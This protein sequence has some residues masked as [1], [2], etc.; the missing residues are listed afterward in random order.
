MFDL[1]FICFLIYS[2]KQP[3]GQISLFPSHWWPDWGPELQNNIANKWQSWHTNPCNFGANVGKHIP[4]ASS[5]LAWK[6]KESPISF[7]F[8]HT[9]SFLSFPLF[10]P[11]SPS[12]PPLLSFLLCSNLYP[13]LWQF[14]LQGS[15]PDFETLC[16][17]WSLWL[18]ASHVN[19]V[20]PTPECHVYSSL[21]PGDSVGEAPLYSEKAFASSW[22][23]EQQKCSAKTGV[24]PQHS[25]KPHTEHRSLNNGLLQEPSQS[26]EIPSECL[27]L[28]LSWFQER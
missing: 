4:F 11:L 26:K 18:E 7:Q 28:W 19:S 9:F 20:A 13:S 21:I 8:T 14:W 5:M 16:S 2:S 22:C 17:G 12:S 27:S 1:S 25:H 23:S 15:K 24:C 10:L 3:V 6:E